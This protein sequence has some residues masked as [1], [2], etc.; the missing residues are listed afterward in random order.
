MALLIVVLPR[1]PSFLFFFAPAISKAAPGSSG[2]HGPI[3]VARAPFR[4]KVT[5]DGLL[6]DSDDTHLADRIR[7]DVL[8][9]R[10]FSE[11]EDPMRLV[12]LVAVG[13]DAVIPGDSSGLVRC[14]HCSSI[15]LTGP[16]AKDEDALLC[17]L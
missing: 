16:S 9:V 7:H 1:R 11:D 14:R 13:V 6:L 3:G 2:I 8:A 10:P 12:R 5:L 17:E 4:L 15:N